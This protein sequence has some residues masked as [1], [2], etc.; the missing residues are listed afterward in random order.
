MTMAN[1]SAPETY[2]VKTSGSNKRSRQTFESILAIIDKNVSSEPQ[3]LPKRPLDEA[4]LL[5]QYT[6]E[7]AQPQQQQQLQFVAHSPNTFQFIPRKP[8]TTEPSLF[9]PASSKAYAS[10]VSNS[11]MSRHTPVRQGTQR[12][13]QQSTRASRSPMLSSASASLHSRYCHVALMAFMH[14]YLCI[15]AGFRPDFVCCEPYSMQ[16]HAASIIVS[17]SATCGCQALI[18]VFTSC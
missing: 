9:S 17:A 16:S 2:S 12:P 7:R 1:A 13:A 15:C 10:P 4:Y 11:L 8:P 5:A 18:V 14:V 3:P 6:A